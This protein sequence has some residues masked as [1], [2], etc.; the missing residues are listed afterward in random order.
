[1]ARRSLA[2]SMA[3][4]V[5]VRRP[6][7]GS[8]NWVRSSCSPRSIRRYRASSAWQRRHDSMCCWTAGS[9]GWLAS[10][11]AGSRS[12]MSSHRMLGPPAL[13]LVV[14]EVAQALAAPVEADLGRRHRDAGLLRDGLVGEPVDVL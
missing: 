12:A 7:A 1:M 14:E 3:A 8:R 6:G 13:G 9:T 11:A 4:R 10:T 2:S 5:A